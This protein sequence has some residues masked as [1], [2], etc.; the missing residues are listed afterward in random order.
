MKFTIKKKLD[1][2]NN[3]IGHNRANRFYAN[4]KK[5]DEMDAI[6]EFLPK[7]KVKNYPI[8]MIFRWHIKS[9]VSDLDNKSTKSI[10]D[11]MQKEGIIE[12]DNIK[13]INEIHHIAIPD[14]EDY[15]DVEIE[16]EI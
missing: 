12:N 2:W 15:V 14:K 8:K 11:C 6:K 7:E 4:K 5:Q 16:E 10:L 3:I 13:Y 1:N 9:K